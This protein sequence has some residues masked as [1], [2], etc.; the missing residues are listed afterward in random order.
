[1]L[2]SELYKAWGA[3]VVMPSLAVDPGS[4][5]FRDRL[6]AAWDDWRVEPREVL[7]AY[8]ADSGRTWSK[9]VVVNEPRRRSDPGASSNDFGPLVAVNAAGVVGVAWRDR[10]ESVDGLGWQLRFAAS[11]D[12]GET[13][14]PSLPV[15]T[16]RMK[17]G[18]DEEWLVT[19][20][21]SRS[22][23]TAVDPMFV[24]LLRQEWSSGGH[25]SGITADANGTFHLLWADNHT[26][27]HQLWTSAI[28]VAGEGVRQGDT[29]LAELEDISRDVEAEVTNVAYE[30]KTQTLT[31]ELR[32]RNISDSVISGPIRVR[33][34]AVRSDVG[35]PAVVNAENGSHGA[36]AIWTI[37]GGGHDD[38]L[39]PS[40]LSAPT[41][42]RVHL[43]DPLVV[44]LV[45]PGKAKFNH[46]VLDLGLRAFSKPLGRRPAGAASPQP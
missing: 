40:E 7:L 15:S 18:Q 38:R 16:G 12:G 27:V 36:G 13:F 11:F 23:G 21:G 45:R 8:S 35:I 9:P 14:T 22:S 24:R 32:L 1:V 44:E 6:Y 19:A 30:R 25:T 39:A 4:R 10:R 29:T 43:A 5:A 42:I 46:E 28:R 20:L 26:G 17:A 33:A 34:V 2:V 37:H 41:A 3:D 31:A